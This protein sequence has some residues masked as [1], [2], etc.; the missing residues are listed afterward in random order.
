MIYPERISKNELL[1]LPLLHFPGKIHLVNDRIEMEKAMELIQEEALLGFDTETR[2][3]FK[4]GEN[5]PVAL[6]QLASETDAFLFQLRDLGLPD[7]LKEIFEDESVLK[8]GVAIHDDIK[9]LQQKSEFQPNGFEDLADI[10]RRFGIITTGLR[11][12]TGIVLK[13]RI[14]TVSYTHLRAHETPEHRGC[15]L[16]R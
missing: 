2:P 12:L 4:R 13:S 16:L 11:N 7:P 8:I 15:R 9:A 1:E 10:A 3:S 14:S 6:L 5:H